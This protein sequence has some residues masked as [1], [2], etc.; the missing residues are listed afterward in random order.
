MFLQFLLNALS[1]IIVSYLVPG[2]HVVSVWSALVAALIL[3]IVNVLVKPILVLLTLPITIVTLG[4][5]YLVI[6][7]LML[8]LVSSVVKGFTVD[9]LGPA[10]IAT[11]ILWVLS[12][13]W[14][15]LRKDTKS[16]AIYQTGQ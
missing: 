16:G 7:A 2:V 11:V 10:L 4:F 8:L 3:G 14:N 9:G 1:L 13:V 15:A 5:F 6:N 12:L